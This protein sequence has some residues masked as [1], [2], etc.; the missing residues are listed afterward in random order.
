[1]VQTKLRVGLY[2]NMAYIAKVKLISEVDA[3]GIFEIT[4]DIYKDA[5]L[6]IENLVHSGVDKTVMADEIKD[7]LRV[8]KRQD[9][10]A[11]KFSVNEE[12]SIL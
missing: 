10:E 12:I 4:Y 8:I 1:M 11:L 6:R 2:L 9:A 5:D 7:K 3:N